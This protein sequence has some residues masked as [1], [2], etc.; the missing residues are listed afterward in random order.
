[1]KYFGQK[2]GGVILDDG[3]YNGP[4]SSLY[5]CCSSRKRTVSVS[6]ISFEEYELRRKKFSKIFVSSFLPKNTD[7]EKNL[8]SFLGQNVSYKTLVHFTK[9]WTQYSVSVLRYRGSNMKNSQKYRFFKNYAFWSVFFFDTPEVTKIVR[10]K[11]LQIFHA[12]NCTCWHREL[13]QKDFPFFRVP[14]C[15]ARLKRPPFS[16]FDIEAFFKKKSPEG[17]TGAPIRFNFCV[18]REL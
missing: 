9:P 16:F 2:N 3:N 7:N 12:P 1:M 4:K 13:D 10:P 5:L 18:F 8:T 15:R 11:V 6:S 14:Q 17:P